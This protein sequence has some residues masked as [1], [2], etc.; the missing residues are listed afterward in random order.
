LLRDARFP[1]AKAGGGAVG[2]QGYKADDQEDHRDET[3]E[4]SSRSHNLK[5]AL[6]TQV[7]GSGVL[8]SSGFF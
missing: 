3:G 8:R 2:E 6:F 5:Y 7:P 4:Q 1:S